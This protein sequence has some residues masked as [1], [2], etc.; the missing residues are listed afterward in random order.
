ML[1]KN[2]E[3]RNVW[4]I[5]PIHISIWFFAG[6]AM[7][8]TGKRRQ[9]FNILRGIWYFISNLSYLSQKRRKVQKKRVKS[10]VELWSHIYRRPSRGYYTQ[11]FKRYL[12][13]GLH[14]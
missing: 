1:Y 11:R 3:W 10:D 6:V 12:K 7:L 5:L 9:G 8:I 4:K 13:I 14:G 2:L